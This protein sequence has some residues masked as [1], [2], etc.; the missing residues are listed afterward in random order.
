MENVSITRHMKID[1]TPD[2][3]GL[4]RLPGRVETAQA[5][6]LS[7]TAIVLLAADRDRAEAL[8]RDLLF[9]AADFGALDTQAVLLLSHLLDFAYGAKQ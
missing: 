8:S 4:F 5:L 9:N 7:L 2:Q 1:L 6:N 3:W